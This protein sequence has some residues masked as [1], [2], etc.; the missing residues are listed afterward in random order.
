MARPKNNTPQPFRFRDP[1]HSRIHRRLRLLVM[2]SQQIVCR[3]LQ[4]D[5]FKLQYHLFASGKPLLDSALNSNPLSL[6]AISISLEFRDYLEELSADNKDLLVKLA[7]QFLEEFRSDTLKLSTRNDRELVKEKARLLSVH[8][9]QLRRAHKYEEAINAVRSATFVLKKLLQPIGTHCRTVLGGLSY[10]E[11]KLLRHHG[12]YRECE[13][14]LT[15]AINYY[16]L[17]VMDNAKDPQNIQL[18]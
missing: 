13:D 1:H 15:D 4:Y 7:S 14:K 9:N 10:V 6:K 8:A 2:R 12:Q 18:A 17:W 3:S 16:S 11:S 5:F